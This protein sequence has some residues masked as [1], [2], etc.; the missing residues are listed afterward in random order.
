MV[1]ALTCIVNKVAFLIIYVNNLARSVLNWY[2]DV[3]LIGK[4]SLS[5]SLVSWHMVHIFNLELFH[6]SSKS[7]F[8]WQNQNADVNTELAFET[9]FLSHRHTHILV[10]LHP[11]DFSR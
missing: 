9:L 7:L 5:S 11:N 8:I 6:F 4:W 10:L 2:Y 3:Q 1:A